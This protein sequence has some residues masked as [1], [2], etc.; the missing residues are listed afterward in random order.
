MSIFFNAFHAPLGAHSS[1]TLGCKGRSGGLGLEMGTPACENVYIGLENRDNEKF[2]LLPFFEYEESESYRYDHDS[3][4]N[5]EDKKNE[6]FISVFKDSS[7]SRDFKTGSD[8]WSAED[9]TFKI[10][11]APVTAVDPTTSSV[12]EQ[13][14]TYCPGVLVELI[15]DNREC[16]KERK[17]VFGYTPRNSTDSLNIIHDLPLG[18]K[19]LAKGR[20]TGIFTNDK[21]AI[22]A[23]GFSAED[24]IKEEIRENYNFGLG[25]TGL[26]QF[27]VPPKSKKSFKIAITFFRDGIVTSGEETSYWYSRFFKTI[28]SVGIYALNN[29]NKYKQLT[30]DIDKDFDSPKLNSAQRF[31]LA[32]SIRSYFGST[33]LLDWDNSPFWVVN[34]GEYRMMNTFDLTVD[35]IFFELK[36]NPWTVK[37]EL[38]MFVKRYS[39]VDKLHFPGEENIYDGGISFTHDMGRE[40]HISRPE[41]STYEQ[42][43]L[44]GCFS[45]MTHEQLINWVLCGALYIKKT[46]DINWLKD[47]KVIFEACLDSMLQ[48]DNPDPKKRNGIMSLDSSR[49]LNGA[50]ITTYDS[51]DESLGQS[52]NNLY[53]AVKSWAAYISMETLLDGLRSVTC[54]EQA[55]KAAITIE[56]HFNNEGYIP[57]IMGESCDSK[58]I[59]AIEGLVFPYYLGMFESV[60]ETGQYGSLIKVLKEHFNNVLKKGICLYNDNGWKL[61]SSADNSWLSKIYLCQYV[62]REILDIKT[63]ATGVDADNAHMMW[64]LKKENLPYAWSD[65]MKSGV[66]HGSLYYP[67][68]VTSILWLDEA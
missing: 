8:T 32:H 31:Q 33:Q 2:K 6:S 41:Y 66:A 68:G 34:E 55:V 7:I 26:L 49:T 59:P 19:G 38:D 17:A 51:L 62:A 4:L 54:K 47:N 44:K 22:P 10:L 35:Q 1:F 42:F 12:E 61:S 16:S 27:K 48:R 60:S 64:L 28:S 15:I 50:E 43:G 67:R 45:H 25:T 3:T 29:F 11:S 56:S 24:I 5:D 46:G 23:S 65:Q 52:R 18:Y 58:I 21:D 20:S 53:M 30:A 63:P 13:M 37:N 36:Q 57:A 39:Y 9:L 40:N 14:F